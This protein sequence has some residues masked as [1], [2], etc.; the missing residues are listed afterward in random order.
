MWE[1][2]RRGGLSM[3]RTVKDSLNRAGDETL[4]GEYAKLQKEFSAVYEEKELTKEKLLESQTNWTLFS[5]DILAISKGLYR[6]IAALRSGQTVSEELLASSQSQIE[7]YEAFLNSS[8]NIFADSRRSEPSPANSEPRQSQPLVEV[9]KQ[10]KSPEFGQQIEMPPPAADLPPPIDYQ[11]IKQ[12][13]LTS[14]DHLKICALLQALRWRITRNRKR[15]GRLM[16]MEEY[17]R[18]DLLECNGTG[19]ILERLL[20]H[21]EKKYV[22]FCITT[23]YRVA[24]YTISLLDELVGENV[25]TKY[26]TEQPKTMPLLADILTGEGIDTPLM[27]RTLATIE[28]CSVRK[29]AQTALIQLGLIPWILTAL[30][31]PE[32]FNPYTL[33]YI[34]ALLMNLALRS[35]GRKVCQDP[36]LNVLQ[37]LSSLLYVEDIE[38]RSHINGTLY[39]ILGL[40]A[41]RAE[42]KVHRLKDEEM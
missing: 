15:S 23:R 16:V 22:Q 7:K 21:P 17:V 18:E 4:R 39:S 24:E 14:T 1:A 35:E 9:G 5:K 19:Y 26:L 8:Q 28:K 32:K 34:T 25:G 12:F 11:R 36:K 41:I 38:I 33:E 31:E 20:E 13:L 37:V 40:P 6:A 29:K 3:V 2:L 42:A 30:K 10:M 27:K